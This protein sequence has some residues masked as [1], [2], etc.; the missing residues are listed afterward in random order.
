[1]ICGIDEAGRGCLCASLFVCGVLGEENTLKNL[2]I[3]DSKK[4]TQSAR[5]AKAQALKELAQVGA[6]AYKLI[7]I[8][9]QEIDTLALGVCMQK[10][11]K[12]IISHF[13]SFDFKTESKLFLF[14]GNTTFGLPR[15]FVDP[16]TSACISLQTLIKG[17]D[18]NLLIAA[19]SILAKS[20]KDSQ[21]IELDKIYPQYGFA[22]H[23]GYG[24]KAHIGAI[25][26]FGLTPLHRKNFCK[27][28]FTPTLL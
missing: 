13:A 6:I 25:E 18:K 26:I 15:E 8:S 23:K 7:E 5:F 10:A 14:D 19:A 20:A 1:M 11:L 22:K 27:N 16:H 2:G 24:T 4:L 28:L 3:K 9:A 21:M 12:E 17:D